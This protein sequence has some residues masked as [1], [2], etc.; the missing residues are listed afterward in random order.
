MA[1]LRFPR[2]TQPLFL[3][4]IGR[5][6]LDQFLARF[7]SELLSR[8]WALPS[9]SVKDTDYYNLVAAA[10]LSPEGLPPQMNEALYA[11]H[12]LATPEGQERLDAAVARTGLVLEESEPCSRADLAMRLWLQAPELLTRVHNEFRLSRLFTFHHFRGHA[13]GE[14]REALAPPINAWL[15]RIEDACDA[16]FTAHRRGRRNTRVQVHPIEGEWWFVVSHGDA[17]K[18]TQKIEHGLPETLQYRPARDDVVVYAPCRDELRIN[19]RSAGERE[20]YRRVFGRELFSAPDHFSERSAYTLEPLRVEGAD[21][22]EPCG[23]TG[24]S[25]VVLRDFEIALPGGFGRTEIHKAIDVFAAAESEGRT[26]PIPARGQLLRATLDVHFVLS[27]KPSKVQIRPPNTLRLSRP[28]ERD[29]VEEFLS[30][31]RFRIPAGS[32]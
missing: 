13:P 18:R 4:Q 11:L 1:T 31:N 17:F 9:S 24:I 22:L 28:G 6:L 3:K 14:R 12:D 21:A 29:A 8:H 27:S 7:S 26:S 15:R 19:A 30:Q 23:A 20:L 32:G 5:P 16:W 25:R 10:M 2:F